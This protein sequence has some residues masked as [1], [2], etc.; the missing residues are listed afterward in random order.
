MPINMKTSKK[1]LVEIVG[2]EG[3]TL[4]KY[5]DMV[6][7]GFSKMP[8]GKVR[9]GVLTIG[10]G[11]TKTEI[12]DLASWPWDK[13][14]TMDEVFEL[15]LKAMKRYENALNENIHREIP[16]HV[17]DALVSWCYN[18]GVGWTG[19]F[20]HRQATLIKR[21]NRG[22]SLKRVAQALMMFKKPKAIIGRRRKE[23][24]LLE[25][26]IYSNN[27]LAALI[28]VSSRGYPMYARSKPI[29]VWEYIEKK[30]DEEPKAPEVMKYEEEDL[31]PRATGMQKFFDKFLDLFR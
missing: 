8:D 4:T 26:G 15:K 1:G 22:E 5:N 7:N 14:I 10:A 21:L 25:K 19:K 11:L 16:Q 27:G 20:G 3:I 12:P 2:H 18:V 17:F 30:K 6:G 31:E 23:A 28:P 9:R 24:L 13:K 29:N